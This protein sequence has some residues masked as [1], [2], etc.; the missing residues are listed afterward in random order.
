MNVVNKP[1]VSVITC[2]Y[3]SVMFLQKTID[4]VR[5]QTFQDFE[6]IFIDGGSTDG[7]LEIIN[8]YVNDEPEK[9]KLV[10]QKTKGLMRARNIGIQCATG[11]Y[12][13]FIDGDDIW[14][15]QKLAR[16]IAFYEQHLEY[17]L[18]FANCVNIDEEGI[19]IPGTG[20][21]NTPDLTIFGLFKHCYIPNPTVMVKKEIYDEIGCFDETLP[22]SEDWDMWLRIAIKYPLAYIPDV[23]AWYRVHR[24]NMSTGSLKHYDYQVHVM[25][26]IAALEPKLSTLLPKRLGSIYM[27]KARK[28][29]K[30]LDKQGARESFAKAKQVFPQRTLVYLLGIFLTYLPRNLLLRF[31]REN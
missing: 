20:K 21:K 26:K 6:Y 19:I 27:V 12:I 2:C 13:C 1:L 18:V 11:R 3:N 5:E 28:Q 14:H 9:F 30:E 25:K 10:H 7:T 22:Y 24:N 17:G 15:T 4:S 16:Q 31:V 23:L 29:L 8:F